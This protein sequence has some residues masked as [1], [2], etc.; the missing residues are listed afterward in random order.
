M[1]L[2][3][4]SGIVLINVE[5][6]RLV[7]KPNK[8]SVHPAKT[9]ISLGIH[10]VWL[11]FAVGMKKAWAL[12]Y[13]LSTQRRLWSDWADAQAD[14]SLR[15]AQSHFVSLSWGGSNVEINNNPKNESDLE[16]FDTDSKCWTWQ[17]TKGRLF[18]QDLLFYYLCHFFFC[19]LHPHVYNMHTGAQKIHSSGCNY[20]SV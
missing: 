10:P 2:I 19:V 17:W 12:R 15:W 3:Q 1:I 9:Q 4:M 6:S 20:Y 11:V 16:M 18:C 13:P 7:T 8:V 14:L 5:M